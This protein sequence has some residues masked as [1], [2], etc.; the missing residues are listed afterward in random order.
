ME[1][2]I[3]VDYNEPEIVDT[4]NDL[5]RAGYTHKWERE[6]TII[7][8][9]SGSSRLIRAEQI[10]RHTKDLLQAFKNNTE[11]EMEKYVIPNVPKN[12]MLNDTLLFYKL[13]ERFP[14]INMYENISP[15]YLYMAYNCMEH[16]YGNIL[17]FSK[18]RHA[19]VCNMKRK[20]KRS[21]TY[22]NIITHVDDLDTYIEL[23]HSLRRSYINHDLMVYMT[24]VTDMPQN[25]NNLLYTFIHLTLLLKGYKK[26]FNTYPDMEDINH[27]IAD[28]Y[29][30]N[31]IGD[32]LCVE[33][34]VSPGSMCK[35]IAKSTKVTLSAKIMANCP[36]L[37]NQNFIKAYR[38]K[39][40]TLTL[41]NVH[42][43]I[44]D[45]QEMNILLNT[46]NADINTLGINLYR[47]ML[48][49]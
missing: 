2:V 44:C 39:E 8:K 3:R 34:K 24:E 14:N 29:Q 21:N 9:G 49:L 4:Y 16:T 10:S 42:T 12:F 13:I 19:M 47:D 5:S 20:R 41:I 1:P 48:S 22:V 43:E 15:L 17:T 26:S 45:V 30:L 31:Q 32:T 28:R 6:G 18:S 27:D 37:R 40:T 25:I 33:E 7:G 35:K 46:I 11:Y 36:I 38:I 23:I